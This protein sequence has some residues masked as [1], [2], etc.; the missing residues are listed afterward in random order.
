MEATVRRR[1]HTTH[2][3]THYWRLVK[4]MDDSQKLELVTMLV[5]SVKP[6]IKRE[7]S[8]AC[9]DS[10]ECEQ[11]RPKVKP[12]KAEPMEYEDESAKKHTVDDFAGAWATMDDDMLDAA[13][14]KFHKDWGGEGTAMEIAEELRGSRENSRTIETW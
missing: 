1:Q 4:D 6:A 10:A 3:I 9:I 7:Q 8:D 2:P 14:A 12:A 13:L 11:A 5:S